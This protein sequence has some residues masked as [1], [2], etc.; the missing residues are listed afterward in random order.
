MKANR[1]IRAAR[2]T[3][4][5]VAVA[6]LASVAAVQAQY[7]ATGDDGITAS[8]KARQFIDEYK[9]NH[10][11]APVPAEIPRM[12]CPKCKN[13]TVTVR[14]TEPK[15]L[16]AKTLVAGEVPTKVVTTHGCNGCW[17]DWNAVGHGKAKVSVASHK[18]TGC[19]EVNLACCAPK[20]G[21]DLATKGMEKKFEVAPLK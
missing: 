14:D 6:M 2:L 3:G 21:S 9:R 13:A 8:P 16:G 11:P 12:A 18:C 4:L 17:T 20:K 5:T 15:G 1:I 19:G 7:K 10:S